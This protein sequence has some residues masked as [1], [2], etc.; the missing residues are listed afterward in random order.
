MLR[1]RERCDFFLNT[2][3]MWNL[4]S[5]NSNLSVFESTAIDPHTRP[6]FLMCKV[7]IVLVCGILI[8]IKCLHLANGTKLTTWTNLFEKND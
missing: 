8:A 4:N 5:N 2:E 6:T 1:E 3:R 7:T